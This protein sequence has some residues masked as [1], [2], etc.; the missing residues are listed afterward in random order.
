MHRAKRCGARTRSKKP[1]QSPAMANGGCRMHDG[2]SL[3]APKGNQNAFKHGRYT[4]AAIARRREI[5]H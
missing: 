1:C 4:A 3:G 5:R 2:A